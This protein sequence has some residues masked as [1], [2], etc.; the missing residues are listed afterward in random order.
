MLLYIQSRLD[1]I[2][3]PAKK[4]WRSVG[5]ALQ[6]SSTDLDLIETEYRALRSPTESLLAK[7]RTF[8]HEPTMA[9]FVRALRICGRNDIADYIARCPWDHEINRRGSHNR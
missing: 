8:Q 4:T 2:E 6:V 5:R 9:E 1:T 3:T 7:L